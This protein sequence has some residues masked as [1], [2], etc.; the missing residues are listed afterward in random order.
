[1]QAERSDEA[2]RAA[3]LASSGADT[4]SGSG[5]NL[6]VQLVKC[7][8]K[9]IQDFVTPGCESIHASG[10]RSLGLRRPQPATF[11]HSRQHR[12]QGSWT[13]TVAVMLQFLKHPLTV[14]AA[15]VSGVVENVDFP[16][17]Q[18]EFS[19]YRIAHQRGMIALSLRNRKA[20][21]LCPVVPFVRGRGTCHAVRG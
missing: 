10:F 3:L 14:D 13:Q 2:A 15:P 11:S 9:L 20:I 16:E 17:R 18:Q 1:M 4:A 6:T 5:A 7:A 8:A 21:T 12:I 19:R